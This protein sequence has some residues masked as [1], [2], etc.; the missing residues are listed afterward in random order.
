MS[1]LEILFLEASVMGFYGKCVLFTA[2][3]LILCLML[4]C[5]SSTAEAMDMWYILNRLCGLYKIVECLQAGLRILKPQ[6]I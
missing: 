4:C 6:W 5:Y 2:T 1:D 3:S